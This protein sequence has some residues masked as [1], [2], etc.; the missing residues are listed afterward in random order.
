MSNPF[1]PIDAIGFIPV[2]PAQPAPAVAKSFSVGATRA[3]LATGQ[4]GTWASDHRAETT[5]FTGWNYVAIHAFAKLCASATVS[6]YNDTNIGAR[7]KSLRKT[8]R[9][10]FG[11]VWKAVKQNEEAAEPLPDDHELVKLLNHPNP[12][13]DGVSFRYEI[14]LQIRLTGGALVW[15]LPNRA[16]R[17]CERYV[18]PR[19]VCE[20]VQPSRDLPMG[21]YRIT[22]AA[23]RWWAQYDPQ[24]FVEM[25]GFYRAIGSIIPME[26]I[27]TI[28]WPHPL[29]KDDYQS[30]ISAGALWND[31]ADMADRARWAQLKN[32]P[33]PS[34]AITPGEGVELDEAGAD[35]AA[36]K[37]NAK[38]CGPDNHG[39]AMVLTGDSKVQNLSTSPKD[40]EYSD[41]FVDL[42]DATLAIHGLPG[43]VAGITDGGSFA[44]FVASL[45]QATILAIQP[46]LDLLAASDG[47]QLAPQFG[48]GLTVEYEAAAIDDPQ[49]IEAMLATDGM[50]GLRTVNEGR[51][52]RGLKPVPWGEVRMS[53]SGGSVAG[54]AMPGLPGDHSLAHG[55]QSQPSTGGEGGI[56]V[57]DNATLN[58]AQITAAREVMIDV[59]TGT[60][61]NDVAIELL[62]G[63][64][65]PRQRA[66]MMIDAVAAMPPPTVDA[67]GK[68]LPQAGGEQSAPSRGGE[69]RGM[70]RRDLI[71]SRKGTRETLTQVASGEISEAYAV[72]DLIAL[73]W[74]EQAAKRLV[75]DAK[76]GAIEEDAAESEEFPAK[77][78]NRLNGHGDWLSQAIRRAWR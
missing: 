61:P 20:P 26:Q 73:G 13:Q 58:G 31:T 45:K 75:D 11:S 64:G 18:L 21:G 53:A 30:P 12:W 56:A 65:I 74:S 1:A 54:S 7:A 19:A 8:W 32:G 42:R 52:I 37:I 9:S 63:V 68:P 50:Y 44:A 38:Y 72:E 10:A 55:E 62:V 28:G 59:R 14:V 39:K 43:V 33:N 41:A 70:K 40:M 34:I 36:A 2:A 66:Q 67:D 5:K 57:G 48:A 77:S 6:V 17:T 4:P 29:Y 71:N 23:M 35:V 25:R 76:D 15:N 69:F 3:A 49:Q 47:Q 51:A 22:P 24:G 16:R 78:L 46:E 60:L 27:Q